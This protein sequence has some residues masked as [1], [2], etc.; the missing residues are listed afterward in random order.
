MNL[1]E[2]ET[3]LTIVNTKSITKTAD[4][5]FLAQPTVSHRLMSLEKQL[6]FPLIV[7]KKGFKTVEITAKGNEFVSI[8]ERWI[9]L[10]KETQALGSDRDCTLL[11]IGCTDSLSIALFSS[12]YRQIYN[13]DHSIHLDIHTHQSSE[14][15][16]LLD[17]H[18]I[19]IGFVYYHLHYRNIISQR[20]YQERLYLV[21][22]DEPVIRKSLIGTEELDPSKELYLNWDA[23][24]QIWHDRWLTGYSSPRISVDTITLLN[25]VWT[26]K[27]SWLIAP[28]SVI[29]ELYRY[30]RLYVSELKNPPPDRVCYK[31]KHRF[32][33]SATEQAVQY[34]EQAL[35]DYLCQVK[36]T[37]H[38]GDVWGE[39]EI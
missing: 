24:F 18:D 11:S 39:S 14:L 3:F 27:D 36:A 6:G 15:Y 33:S 38:I 23:N 12:F 35:N 19:D 10:W 4:A 2:I 16:G 8:A 17:H 30:R 1:A 26:D 32:P 29:K 37:L 9:S 22:S 34:F 5:L 13:G 28:E 20:I 31:I 25:H 7:R 21:Q